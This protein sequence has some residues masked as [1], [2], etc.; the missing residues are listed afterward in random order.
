MGYTEW[1]YMGR[2]SFVKIRSSSYTGFYIDD[3]LKSLP[4][5]SAAIDLMKTVQDMLAISNLRLHKIASNCPTVMQ[6]FPS[7]DH[8]MVLR[9]LDLDTNSPPVQRSLGLRRSSVLGT[10]RSHSR[11][12][13]CLQLL[14]ANSIHLVLLLLLSSKESTYYDSS[15]DVSYWDVPLKVDKEMEWIAWRDSL[16]S[17]KQLEISR[18]YTTACLS[19]AQHTEVHVFSDAFIKAITAWHISR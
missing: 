19:T 8:A 9:D 10:V 17:L 7:T 1:L 3:G 18:A 5:A 11:A 12:E 15:S 14:T 4:S 16:Q 2:T 13:E 6:A